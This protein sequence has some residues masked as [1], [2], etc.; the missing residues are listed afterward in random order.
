MPNKEKIGFCHDLHPCPRLTRII[1]GAAVTMS[2]NV[3]IQGV[4]MF[5][6]CEAEPSTSN[7]PL[8]GKGVLILCSAHFLVQI[9]RSQAETDGIKLIKS[10]RKR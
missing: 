10:S 9:K 6:T 5:N 3:C 2:K 1:A 4:F 7:C 8:D